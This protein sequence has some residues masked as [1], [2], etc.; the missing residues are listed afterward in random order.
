MHTLVLRV[1]CNVPRNGPDAKPSLGNYCLKCRYSL[2]YLEKYTTDFPGAV[3]Y[4]G[5]ELQ[6]FRS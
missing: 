6:A 3:E 5:A 1:V 4:Y 2:C